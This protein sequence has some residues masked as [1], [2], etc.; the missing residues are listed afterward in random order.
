MLSE[1]RMARIVEA[2]GRVRSKRLSCTEAA[3][4]LGISDRHFRRLRD[5]Y[6]EG[7][8]EAIADK[9]RGRPA[10]NKAPVDAADFVADQFRTRYY[11]FT[12]KHF[13]EELKRQGFRY[14]YTW[15]K[16]VLYL[17]GLVKPA[18]TR[19]PHRKKRPRSPLPGMLV[20]QDGSTHEWFVGRPPCDLIVTLD[21]ATGTLLSAFFIEQEGTL[22]SFRGL[23]E[24]IA[25]HGLFSSFYTD[26]GAHYFH[27]P[28]VGGKVDKDNPT[29]VGRALA[30][31]GITHI[32]SYSPEARGRMERVFGTLQG[33][34]PQSLR[35]AG[36][37]THRTANAWLKASYIPEFN[38]RFGVAP[39]EEGTAFV[40]FVGDLANI[41]C[42]QDERVVSKDNTV[43]WQGLTLQIPEHKHRRHFV[44]AQ[45]KVHAYPDGGLAIFHG[46]RLLAGYQS[47]GAIRITSAA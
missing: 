22:S 3:E 42:I 30:Q 13:H 20:F 15:T 25:E 10:S 11:D 26:R 5:S 31:L 28:E 19:G 9:R 12:P 38:A 24:T 35:L 18:K 39:A 40:A 8:A 27:T 14:S 2:I 7:G 34:L 41:L 1:I 29:Q 21:D 47:N 4:F 43:R 17:R 6:E 45:V 46:P 36:I 33:R 32:P 23:A 44:K 37:R 16:S